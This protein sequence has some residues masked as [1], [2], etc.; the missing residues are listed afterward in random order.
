M[1]FSSMTFLFAFLPVVVLVY[2]LSP[3]QLKN[4][5][6]LVASLFF[7]AWGEP[8]NI[9]LMLLS[10]GINYVFGRII[11]AD[12]AS[13]SKM[14]VW[15]LGFAVLWNV[16]ILGIFK[17][18]SGISQTFHTMLPS[19]IPVVKIALPIGIS[20]YTFQAISYLVDVYRGTTRAQNNLINFA[21]YIAMFPQLIAGPIVRYEDVEQQIRSRRVTIAGF[22]VGCEFFIRGMVKKVL[23]A[24]LLG[25]IFV[26]IQALS[27][28][29]S[30]IVTAWIGAILYTLQ[31]YYDFSGYSDMAI[32]L[33][34]MFGFRFPQNFNYPYIAESITDFWRRWHMSL[35]G[36]FQEYLYI[37]LGGNR[38]GKFKTYRNLMIVFFMTGLWHGASWNF[39]VWG[40]F[41]GV[42]LVLER[43][44]PIEKFLRF[45]LIQN[46]YAL[47]VVMVGWVFFRAENLTAA[48]DYLKRMFV[49]YK[50][51]VYSA[52]LS[53]EFMM[54]AALGLVSC[55]FLTLIFD[56][57]PVKTEYKFGFLRLV[58]PAWCAVIAY[59]SVLL[60]AS[61]TYNPF[62]YFRF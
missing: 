4:A 3:K 8:R 48:L 29:Q 19:L 60:L 55:G 36:W 5:I 33:G 46:I 34:R 40:L 6:L 39:V 11:E 45:R 54:V 58:N 44:L 24:N 43:M 37:P 14:R 28:V 26:R 42:F 12:R 35:S 59:F 20:F 23:F 50:T 51:D 18:V 57:L 1:V 21:L 47:L 41:H 32:G 53:N 61:N 52:Y 38:E 7:Y 22:G 56:K 13:Q 31:I 2:M 9:L 10:I 25:Q 30:S 16:L 17:Y 15:N 49:P 27:N 62:I